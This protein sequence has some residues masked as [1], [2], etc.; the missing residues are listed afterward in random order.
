VRTRVALLVLAAAASALVVEASAAERQVPPM[1]VFEPSSDLCRMTIDGSETVR[2]TATKA[3]EADPAVSSD[4][5]RIAFTR[6]TRQ[7]TD[8]LWV[9]DLQGERATEDRLRATA[10]RQVRQHR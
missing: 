2:L 4:G 7:G 9:A 3:V 8:E 1:L 5:L 10:E 6:G